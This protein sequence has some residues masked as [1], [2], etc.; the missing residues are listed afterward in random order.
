M[1]PAGDALRILETAMGRKAGGSTGTGLWSAL[2]DTRTRLLPAA[3]VLTCWRLRH[4]VSPTRL[5]PLG[6]LPVGDSANSHAEAP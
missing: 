2:S 4:R 5:V 1:S 3:K 6:L